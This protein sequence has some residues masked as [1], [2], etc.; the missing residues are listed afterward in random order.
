MRGGLQVGPAAL[1]RCNST[2]TDQETVMQTKSILAAVATTFALAA[3]FAAQAG[4]S[5]DQ[6]FMFRDA[7]STRAVGEVRAEARTG[8]VPTG[9]LALR[10][11]A[12]AP[13]NLSRSQV[14]SQIAL[15]P[16]FEVMGA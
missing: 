11:W 2:H 12:P 10:E 8:A 1:Q 14:R 16:I 4:E 6:I 5:S 9:E 15:G 7:P 3:P 13:S